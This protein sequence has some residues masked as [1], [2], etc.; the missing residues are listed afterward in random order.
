MTRRDA[1]GLAALA[2]LGLAARPQLSP[3]KQPV[4]VS[5]GNG[6]RT[7]AKAV[8]MMGEGADTLDAAVAGVN[9]VEL[10]PRDMS[11]G[12][13]G[14]PNE[15]GVV[16][17]DACVMHGPTHRAGAVAS[18]RNIKTPSQVAQRVMER[19]DHVLLVAEGALEF[20]RMHGFTE[21]NL[22]TEAARQ[23]WLRWK[24]GLSD[25]DD[26]MS[27]S[28][29]PPE[30]R[31]TGTIT[32]LALNPEGDLS[33]TTTTSG[34]AYK[35]P[36]RVGDSPLIGAGLY[37]DNEIGACGSTG[38]GEANILIGGS[39]LVVELMRQG[40]D[41]EEAVMEC[42]DRV[43]RKTVQG[44]LVRDNGDPNFQLQFYALR[45]D[46]THAGGCIQPGSRYAVHE[47]EEARLAPC[48]ALL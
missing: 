33:G 48:T 44:H 3:P 6:M 27:D 4:A 19:T 11:V 23:R 29:S 13:G 24:E 12:Y 2:P 31:P 45:K 28:M 39:R 20:A 25:R 22:L 35:I 26:Y 32:C 34:L 43:R 21:E 8:E 10:D 38:R 41:P 46:G 30:E 40:K 37:V 14:L 18:L 15:R 36:G 47:G 5:S 17:L 7:V 16:E 9:I 1:L 42:L